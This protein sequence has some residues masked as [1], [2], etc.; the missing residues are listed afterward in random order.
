MHINSILFFSLSTGF[1]S[2]SVAC[3]ATGMFEM[4]YACSRG[5]M[6][7][8][9]DASKYVFWDS[10]HPTEKTNSIVAK[11]VVLRVLYQFLQ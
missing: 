5:A 11:Y 2:T 9:T 7:S 4:G 3:C 8:C 1:E 6:F 10:F